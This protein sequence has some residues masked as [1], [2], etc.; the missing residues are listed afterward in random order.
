LLDERGGAF[1]KISKSLNKVY[2]I[3]FNKNNDAYLITD[4]GIL[5][6]SN[7]KTYLPDT[8]FRLNKQ[9][10]GWPK[11]SAVFMDDEDN[12]WVGSGFGEWG[13]ELFVF[14]TKTEKF[15]RPVLNGFRI[16]LY[17]VKS[18][19][20]DGNAIFI[21]FGLQHMM[22]SGCI[23]KF[24]NYKCSPVF[25]SESRW[26]EDIDTSRGKRLQG[27]EYIGPAAYS[28]NDHCI[29]FYSQHG[30]FK[31]EKEKDLSKIDNWIKIASPKLHWKSGQPDAVGS[32]MNVLKMN[33]Q[34]TANYFC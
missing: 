11:P 12:I 24:T 27:G 14:N 29:Y 32:P 18:I 23:M 13:G 34:A 8:S 1:K 10:R 15:I 3:V 31:G 9:I 21:S 19:F 16:E 5:D 33:S 22:T 20:S 25:V 2:N 6:A 4:K 28:Q 30:I 7:G 17:P 26:V